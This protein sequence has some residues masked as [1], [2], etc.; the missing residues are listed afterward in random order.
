VEFNILCVLN[1]ANV[2]KPRNSSTSSKS[3]GVDNVQY[4]PISEFDSEGNLLPFTIRPEQYG[5]FLC[6]MFDLWWPERRKP[7]NSFYDNL[8]EALAGQ[9][10]GSCTMHET[11]DSYVVIEYNGDVYPLPTSSLRRTGRSATSR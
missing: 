6:E 2:E 7:Q 4:I 3:L 11:C 1:N 9:K 5:R 10:P 8:A